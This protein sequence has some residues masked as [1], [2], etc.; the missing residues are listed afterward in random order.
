M[1]SVML[2]EFEDQHLVEEGMYSDRLV[3]LLD[4]LH[5]QK[6]QQTLYLRPWHNMFHGLP[7]SSDGKA[8]EFSEQLGRINE[9]M[10]DTLKYC[11]I[12]G[13]HY[14]QGAIYPSTAPQ[15][16]RYERPELVIA[17]TTDDLFET[18]QGSF[19]LRS[20]DNTCNIMDQICHHLSESMRGAYRTH[21]FLLFLFGT[22]MRILY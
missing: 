6:T 22:K 8:G 21:S 10:L 13:G 1:N 12:R 7:R 2:A 16:G 18:Y 19:Q 11:T 20:D 15:P 4:L 9:L 17:S 3:R 5:L 14:V